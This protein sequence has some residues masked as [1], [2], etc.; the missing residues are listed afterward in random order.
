MMGNMHFHCFLR[1]V[2]PRCIFETLNPLTDRL[3]VTQMRGGG[4]SGGLPISSQELLGPWT[5]YA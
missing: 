2:L 1:E 5:S 3:G 4:D